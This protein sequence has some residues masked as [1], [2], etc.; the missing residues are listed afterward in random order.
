MELSPLIVSY[1][2]TQL[3]PRECQPIIKLPSINKIPVPLSSK[4][5]A[6]SDDGG[7]ESLLLRIAADYDERGQ[8]KT[9]S[10]LNFV[11]SFLKR[12]NAVKHKHY[13]NCLIEA[14]GSFLS[15]ETSAAA[16]QDSGDGRGNAID[17]SPAH[18]RQAILILRTHLTQSTS[19]RS[20]DFHHRV[21]VHRCLVS[22]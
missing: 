8:G 16:A 3:G 5:R 20:F 12:N 7:E 18:L 1:L 2:L 15:P 14:S 21:Y 17:R 10:I 22:R 9:V 4:E 19:A 6:N 11:Y 13:S